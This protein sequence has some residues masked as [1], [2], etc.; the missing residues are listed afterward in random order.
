MATTVEVSRDTMETLKKRLAK[1]EI[2][3][4]DL[5]IFLD[6][7]KKMELDGWEVFETLESW[8][9]R[10]HNGAAKDGR[11]VFSFKLRRIG[12]QVS[13]AYCKVTKDNKVVLIK[14][15]LTGIETST[16]TVE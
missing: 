5:S 15:E 2:E 1:K 14:V 10:K 3:S 6:A 7:K 4:L 13:R 8:D 12:D 9:V 16:L 11:G